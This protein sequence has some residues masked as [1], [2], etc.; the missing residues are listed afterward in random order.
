MKRTTIFLPDG[1]HESL[2]QEAFRTRVSMAELIRLRLEMGGQKADK[3]GSDPLARVEGA[4]RHGRLN[5]DI[6][7]ALYGD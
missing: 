3:P 2:R 7:E 6:D 4:V 1:L 5:Q